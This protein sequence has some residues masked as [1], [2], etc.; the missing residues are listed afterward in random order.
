[1]E[2]KAVEKMH[3]EFENTSLNGWVEFKIYSEFER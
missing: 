2:R 1:M 3:F